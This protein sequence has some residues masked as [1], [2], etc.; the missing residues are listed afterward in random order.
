MAQIEWKGNGT[1][2]MRG[3]M[4]QVEREEETNFVCYFI[5]NFRPQ[6]SPP[7]ANCRYPCIGQP[8]L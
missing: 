4:S 1:N 7:E 3:K 6:N 2:R 5:I 8:R